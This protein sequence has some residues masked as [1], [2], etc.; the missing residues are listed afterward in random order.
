MEEAMLRQSLI[1]TALI[2]SLCVKPA[3][4]CGSAECT[5]EEAYAIGV[6]MVDAIRAAKSS[7]E[8]GTATEAKA[9]LDRATA[10]VRA[11]K[12]AAL[13]RFNH[14][15]PQFRDRDLFV[16]CFNG[17]DGKFTAHEALVGQDVRMLRDKTGKPFGEKMYLNAKEGQVDTIGYMSPIAGAPEQAS[18]RADITRIGDQVC[19]VSFYRFNR[20]GTQ[21]TE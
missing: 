10:A 15:D 19:G 20:P 5:E 12:A 8:H 7:A 17:K 1:W 9:M 13:T 4:A 2:A 6:A 14:N 21:P 3:F 18:K 16:F 11:D